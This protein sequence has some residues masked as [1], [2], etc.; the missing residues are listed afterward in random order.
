MRNEHAAQ[1]SAT[2]STCLRC[3]LTTHCLRFFYEYVATCFV[4]PTG[5]VVAGGP[6]RAGAIDVPSR[7]LASACPVAIRSVIS[8]PSWSVGA[9]RMAPLVASI[10]RLGRINLPGLGDYGTALGT[11]LGSV[12]RA[13]SRSGC[14]RRFELEHVGKRRSRP[15]Q[16]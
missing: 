14:C 12:V 10:F 8:C 3:V 11:R 16:R 2:A 13:G 4:A 7:S 1:A 15:A 5:L 9:T 6:A